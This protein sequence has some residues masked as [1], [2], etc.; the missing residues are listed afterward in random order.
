MCFCNDFR[1]KFSLHLC[2]DQG[3]LLKPLKGLFV[4]TILQTIYVNMHIPYNDSIKTH[5]HRFR[6]YRHHQHHLQFRRLQHNYICILVTFC[7]QK[8]DIWGPCSKDSDTHRS[9]FHR[10][11]SQYD[12][13]SHC[14]DIPRQAHRIQLR[15]KS[16]HQNEDMI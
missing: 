3:I 15:K 4:E 16:L 11:F 1:V 9:A 13:I 12:Q 6:F 5:L 10:I 7:G 14:K 2:T 8:I